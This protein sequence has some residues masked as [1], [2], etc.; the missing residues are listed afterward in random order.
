LRGG[1]AAIWSTLPPSVSALI[2]LPEVDIDGRVFLFAIAV[3]ALAPLMFAL[4]PALQA[5]RLPPMEALRGHGGGVLRGSRLR[6]LLVGGQVAISTVLLIL[7][8]TLAR[9]GSAI[10]AI[11]LGY[12]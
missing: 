7:A 11:D 6:S 10:G 2:R 5:A 1:I 12:Q 8:V 9:N 4:L 3:S